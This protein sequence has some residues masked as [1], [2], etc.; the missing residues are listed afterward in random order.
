ME[1]PTAQNKLLKKCSSLGQNLSLASRLDPSWTIVKD[2]N[3]KI[4]D[5]KLNNSTWAGFALLGILI[6]SLQ[7]S[8]SVGGWVGA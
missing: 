7:V 4:T 1:I 2:D 5:M 8:S 3:L 6:I